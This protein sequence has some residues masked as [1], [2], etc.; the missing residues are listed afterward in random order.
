LN[1]P[2]NF[3]HTDPRLMAARA[4]IQGSKLEL[5]TMR[6]WLN[7]YEWRVIKLPNKP[8]GVPRM[9]EQTS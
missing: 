2:G 1:P 9:D 3:G 7:D 6:Y 4:V 8:R 5:G